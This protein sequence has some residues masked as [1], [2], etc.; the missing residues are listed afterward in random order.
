MPTLVQR[1]PTQRG[2]PCD[3]SEPVMPDY[4]CDKDSPARKKSHILKVTQPQSLDMHSL[5]VESVQ[6]GDDVSFS[7][8]E[9]IESESAA[10]KRAWTL[11]FFEDVGIS[12][13]PT[14]PPT[15]KR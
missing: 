13:P 6:V 4:A 2:A 3:P 12:P 9:E 8:R 15:P 5:P 14:P 1:L 11:R 7:Q 10:R